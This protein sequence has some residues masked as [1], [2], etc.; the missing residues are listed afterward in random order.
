[1]GMLQTGNRNT[2]STVILWVLLQLVHLFSC[3]F[4]LLCITNKIRHSLDKLHAHL[5]DKSEVHGVI[6]QTLINHRN[7]ARGDRWTN[8]FRRVMGVVVG[9]ELD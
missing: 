5:I 4:V 8:S 3:W 6:T 2:T 7:L 9:F 1:M